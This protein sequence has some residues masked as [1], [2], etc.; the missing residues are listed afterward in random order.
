MYCLQT[1][2]AHPRGIYF[3]KKMR[4]SLKEHLYPLNYWFVLYELTMIYI[5]FLY[6]SVVNED[7][8]VIVIYNRIP[9]TGSTSF[10]HLPYELCDENKFNVLLLN[11]SNPHSMTFSDRI[12]FANN[13]SHWYEKMPALYHGHFAYFDVQ[14]MGV[15]TGNV[16]F[17]NI[18]IVRQ[19][20]ER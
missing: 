15:Q 4:I 10:M 20:L 11:I 16:K 13:V 7:D 17:I 14:N 2:F 12:F 5:F 8:K 18:N 3:L 1:F 9:K 19:P 6:F